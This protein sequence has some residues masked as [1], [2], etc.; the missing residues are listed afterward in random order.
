LY[1]NFSGQV[2]SPIIGT[3]GGGNFLKVADD[4][5]NNWTRAERWA[6][7]KQF[8]DEAIANEHAFLLSDD[9]FYWYERAVDN[10]FTRELH[11]LVDD[12][13]YVLTKIGDNQWLVKLGEKISS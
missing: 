8:L 1:T 13:G 5:W 7:N 11:Y 6:N 10:I 4:V 12:L 2:V 3:K 9:F